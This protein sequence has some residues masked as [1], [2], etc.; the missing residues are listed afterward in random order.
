MGEMGPIYDLSSNLS[1][2]NHEEEGVIGLLLI[3]NK[4][5][6]R[7]VQVAYPHHYY[8]HDRSMSHVEEHALPGELSNR[9]PLQRGAE[10]APLEREVLNNRHALLPKRSPSPSKW[11]LNQDHA[12]SPMTIRFRNAETLTDREP[13]SAVPKPR[14]VQYRA[15]TSPLSKMVVDPGGIVVKAEDACRP[16]LYARAGAFPGM[17]SRWRMRISIDTST[18]ESNIED[19]WPRPPMPSSKRGEGPYL[20]CPLSRGQMV[21]T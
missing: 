11:A 14:G 5:L 20:V 2:D 12:I 19:S 15:V 4:V 8:V 6:K 1:L 3:A 18:T 16:V 10:E 7:G 21:R 17:V 13:S 9:D